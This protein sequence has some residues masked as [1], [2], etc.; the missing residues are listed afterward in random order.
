MPPLKVIPFPDFF[1]FGLFFNDFNFVDKQQMKERMY[2]GIV[3]SIK[4]GQFSEFFA[5]K[6][7]HTPLSVIIMNGQRNEK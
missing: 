4:R 2:A 1:F 6:N 7:K 5:D 3:L